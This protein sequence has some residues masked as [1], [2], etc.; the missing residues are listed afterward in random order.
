[1]ETKEN[2]PSIIPKR[3]VLDESQ[4]K[5]FTKWLGIQQKGTEAG[6]KNIVDY[7]ARVQEEKDNARNV[8]Q[9]ISVLVK[10]DTLKPEDPNDSQSMKS[11]KEELSYIKAATLDVQTGKIDR[12]QTLLEK[13]IEKTLGYLTLNSMAP[14]DRRRIDSDFFSEPKKSISLLKIIDPKKAAHYQ[15]QLKRR[16]K[17]ETGLW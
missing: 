1:M 7:Y 6:I 16:E 5:Q 13:D 11:S 4:K 8:L 10:Y 15:E 14:E 12:V 3:I 17:Y 2:V 9:K